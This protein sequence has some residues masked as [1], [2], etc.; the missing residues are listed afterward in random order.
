[1]S[2]LQKDYFVD[3]SPIESLSLE[4]PIGDTD[5]DNSDKENCVQI[6]RYNNND[7]H[8]VHSNLGDLTID[9]STKKIL[10]AV[11]NCFH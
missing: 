2:D 8:M 7:N 9:T 11:N 5:C 6:L 10:K 3:K 1:M 4:T